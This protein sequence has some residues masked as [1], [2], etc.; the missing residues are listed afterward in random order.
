MIINPPETAPKDGR[1]ISVCTDD[2]T[3]IDGVLYPCFVDVKWNSKCEW[4]DTINGTGIIK[5]H[6][7]N[8]WKPL[9]GGTNEP[10]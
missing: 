4:W 7:V 9:E 2:C 8:G 5:D 10:A 1:S 3:I 6:N